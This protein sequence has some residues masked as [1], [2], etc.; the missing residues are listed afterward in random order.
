MIHERTLPGLKLLAGD[1]ACRVVNARAIP[2]R[3]ELW[4]GAPPPTRIARFPQR[5]QAWI[6]GRRG[7]STL[8][9]AFHVPAQ[10]EM[11]QTGYQLMPG[12]HSLLAR[13]MKGKVLGRIDFVVDG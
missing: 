2:V 6:T 5:V 7:E 12:K 8:L 9:I 4:R 3:V 13:T 11:N 10:Q 1:S